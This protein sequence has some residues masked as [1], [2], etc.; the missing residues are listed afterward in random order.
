MPNYQSLQAHKHQEENVMTM[1]MTYKDGECSTES[2]KD[3]TFY[4]KTPVLSDKLFSRFSAFIASEVGIKMPPSKRTMLQCRLQKRMRVLGIISYED[5][6]EYIFDHSDRKEVFHFID[7]VTTNKTDFFREPRHF[8]IL[9]TSVLPALLDT[10]SQSANRQIKIWSAACS[11]GEEPYT[12]AIVVSEFLRH[13]RGVQYTILATDIS[14]R[15]LK[16]A[17]NGIYTEDEV[18]PIPS[19]LRPRYLLRS[20]DKAKRQVRIVPELRSRIHFSRLNLLEDYSL[21]EKMDIIFCRNVLIY[22]DRDDQKKV[23]NRLCMHLKEGGY[24]FIGHSETL[25][26]FSSELEQL[27]PTVY[28]K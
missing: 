23:L 16:E 18:K 9:T 2:P 3:N 22:F 14:T 12:L 7:V 27:V 8:E 11:T 6:Y 10:G 4:Y 24:L 19:L 1:C 26:G 13:H 15:V 21:N 5:Y 25:A 28:R 17:R 20:K